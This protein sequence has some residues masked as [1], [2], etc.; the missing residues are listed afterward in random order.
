MV[1]LIYMMIKLMWALFL[2][3][4]SICLAM[5]VL[6]IVIICL[7]TR[8]EPAARQWLHSLRWGLHIL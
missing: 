6:P 3:S 7:L 4:A 8:N 1:F 2:F 5:I